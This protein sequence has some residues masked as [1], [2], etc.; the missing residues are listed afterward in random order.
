VCVLRK[1][2]SCLAHISSDSQVAGLWCGKTGFVPQ[3]NFVATNG[4]YRLDLAF[5]CRQPGDAL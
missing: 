5:I 3:L 1:A 2:L 4:E